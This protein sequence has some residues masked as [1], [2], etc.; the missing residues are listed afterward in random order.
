MLTQVRNRDQKTLRQNASLFHQAVLPELRGVISVCQLVQKMLNC[1]NCIVSSCA[2]LQWPHK[3]MGDSAMQLLVFTLGITNEFSLH[4]FFVIFHYLF[5]Y[6]FFLLVI[7]LQFS[8]SEQSI[9]SVSS[10]YP[11]QWLNA[12][13]AFNRNIKEQNCS[14]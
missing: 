6:F 2:T 14:E 7:Y 10:L 1:T 8:Q 9:L 5:Y 3:S 13:K 12:V 11:F 4:F